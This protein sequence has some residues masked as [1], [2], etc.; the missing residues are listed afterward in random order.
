[1]KTFKITCSILL[2]ILLATAWFLRPWWHG[3][4]M[5]IYIHPLGLIV[6]AA[7]LLLLVGTIKKSLSDRLGGQKTKMSWPLAMGILVIIILS[8]PMALEEEIAKLITAKN[9]DFSQRDSLP[10]ITPVRLLPK[11]VADR[12]AADSFQN[13]QEYLGASPI[14][15]VD[16]RLKR[17]SPRYPEGLILYLTRK[18]TGFV[19]IDASTTE[20]KSEI[21]DQKFTY[22][23]GIGLFD[24]LY[25][26]LYKKRYFVNYSEPIYLKDPLT[27]DWT[28]VVPYLS[29]RYFPIRMPF[30]GGFMTVSANGRI[31]D[32][33]PEEAADLPLTKNNRVFPQELARYYTES[34]AYKQ[35]LIN[36]WF[37]HRDQPE[38]DEVTAGSQPF[39][40]ATN[41]GFKEV[42][43]AKPLGASYGIFK[44]FIFDSTTGK[45]EIINFSE[46]S[47][48]TGPVAVLE[49]VKRTFP[50][51]DYNSFYLVE[52]RPVMI[53]GQLYWLVSLINQSGAGV[54]K[55]VLVRAADNEVVEL[56][57][58]EVV[59]RA[60][61]SGEIPLTKK[62]ASV[63][64]P[65]DNLTDLLQNIEV[66]ENELQELRAK[67]EER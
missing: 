53:S 32:H 46:K 30:W 5:G 64:A 1:M 33:R 12:Y 44:I 27:S 38:I 29:Y 6:A 36:K 63:V 55:T 22:A 10:T 17:V 39:H 16:G 14:V 40:L 11:E 19:L 67:I 59:Q 60:V 20:R 13:P 23:G 15:L 25:F 24:N 50:M 66:I 48:L 9:I 65:P 41:E 37:L 18:M 7:I 2:V 52:S 45:R 35:G 3:I 57:S 47:Q 43:V 54:A 21:I 26:Q 31:T 62:S 61:T 51:I 56:A 4:L 58:D 8:L 34:Y 28:M 49:Y 42:I